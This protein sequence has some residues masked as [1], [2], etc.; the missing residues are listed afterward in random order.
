MLS[1]DTSG[2]YRSLLFTLCGLPRTGSDGGVEA[3]MR[4]RKEVKVEMQEV[5]RGK[6]SR[7]MLDPADIFLVDV[8]FEIF[9]WVGRCASKLERAQA[10][11]HAQV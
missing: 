2:S 3:E 7:G 6:I 9:V 8:G 5:A 10:L 4:A 11:Q 1:N